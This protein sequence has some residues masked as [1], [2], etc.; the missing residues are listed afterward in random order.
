[1]TATPD[2]LD[3][4]HID[5]GVTQSATLNKTCSSVQI[6]PGEYADRIREAG[7][8]VFP[9]VFAAE[10][11]ERLQTAIESIPDGEAVRRKQNVYGVR[12]L[13][14]ISPPIRSL[15]ASAEIRQFV[16]PILGEDAFATRAIF[17]NKVPSANWGLGWHQDC[18]VSVRERLDVAGFVGW[19]CKAGVWHVEPPAEVLA[20]M[21]AVRVH[22]D[23]CG[24]DNG[25]LRVLP[26][27][28]RRGRLADGISEWKRDAA[29]VTCIVR[30]GGVV[31]MCPLIL[32]CSSK[33]RVPT[34]RRVVHIEFANEQLPGG[35]EWNQRISPRLR[36]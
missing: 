19:R 27:S 11:V 25:P 29:A 6:D 24:P 12:N 15:A 9:E 14:E 30:R 34:N 10:E 26:G 32:H 5:G 33:A 20:G 35:L 1:M 18:V 36:D 7:F 21:I 17:F 22:L 4:A 13:L 8:A 3:S 23:E 31:S 28:H 16:T 2:P